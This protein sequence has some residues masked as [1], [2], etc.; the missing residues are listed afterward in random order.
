[1]KDQTQLQSLLEF[2][3]RVAEVV[4]DLNGM[5]ILIANDEIDE[6]DLNNLTELFEKLQQ[7]EASVNDLAD[8]F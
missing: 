4:T 6:G 2:S 5:I 7:V 8:L 3:D 1:M